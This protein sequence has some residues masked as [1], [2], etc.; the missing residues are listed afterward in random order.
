MDDWGF[1]FWV[2]PVALSAALCYMA[3]E[4]FKSDQ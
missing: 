2:V 3:A 4:G 1:G